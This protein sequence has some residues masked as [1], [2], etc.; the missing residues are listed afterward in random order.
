MRRLVGTDEELVERK[1]YSHGNRSTLKQFTFWMKSEKHFEF[2]VG[3]GYFS[4]NS[5]NV[6]Y[7]K[8]SDPYDTFFSMR[9]AVK[10]LLG[11]T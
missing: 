5:R 9:G 1:R 8:E 6:L 4:E 10:V 11:R 2:Q 3:E 7:S